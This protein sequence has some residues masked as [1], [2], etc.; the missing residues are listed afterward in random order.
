MTRIHR[1]NISLIVDDIAARGLLSEE[2][3]SGT[4]R[5]RTPTLLSLENE[6]YAVLGANVRWAKTTIALASLSGKI[7][8]TETFLTPPEPKDLL[9]AIDKSYKAILSRQATERDIRHFAISIPGMANRAARGKETIWTPAIPSLSEWDMAGS[10]QKK[11]G[12]PTTTSN[13]AHLAA[14]AVLRSREKQKT[15]PNDFVFVMIG[16]IGAGSGVVIQQHV[17][18]GFDATFAGEVGHMV[19]DPQGPPCNCG[20][21]GCWNLYVSD[22]ATL[23]RYDPDIPFTQERF[24]EFLAKVN[25]GSPKALDAL[26]KTAEYL[27]LGLA[28]IAVMI[29]PERIVLG[30]AIM[31]CWPLLREQLKKMFF[32]PHHFSLIQPSELPADTLF[33]QGAIEKALDQFFSEPHLKTLSPRKA[34]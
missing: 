13:N 8:D 16:D 9:S 19:V 22:T 30:G 33:L 4:A 27:C 23:K 7:E 21:R 17:Y 1:S 15:P 26:S 20:R 11:L 28:N 2:R 25:A 3:A 5:G 14:T 18:S 6:R 12:V 24:Q 31:Q 10:V 34:K 29:N 32:L